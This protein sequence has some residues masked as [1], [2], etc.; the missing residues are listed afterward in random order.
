[1]SLKT[2]KEKRGNTLLP[3][4]AVS[5]ADGDLKERF[6]GGKE[7]RRTGIKSSWEKWHHVDERENLSAQNS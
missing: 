5:G 4:Q 3:L 1:M 7:Y 2:S 6:E